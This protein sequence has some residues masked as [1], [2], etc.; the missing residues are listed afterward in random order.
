MTYPLTLTFMFLVFWRPQEWLVPAMYGWP[1]LDVIMFFAIVGL[2]MEA[3]QGQVRVPKTPAIWLCI[4]LWFATLASH[5]PSTYFKGIVDT[6]PDSFK[7]CFFVILLV[8]VVDRPSRAR[9]VILVL[10]AAAILMTVHALMQQRLGYGFAGQPPL[11]E[12]R[13][14]R[15]VWEVRSQFFGIFGD[16]NDLAQFLSCTIPLVFA[17]PRRMNAIIFCLCCGLAWYIFQGL[18]ACHSR[19]GMIALTTVG[20]CIVFLRLPIRWLPYAG[21]LALLGFLIL[22]LKA[23]LWLDQSARERIVFW[24]MA[25][26]VFKAH[27]LFGIGYGM[28]WQVIPQSR[29]C[30]NAF[31]SCY[32]E[33]GLFGYWFWFSLLQLG[34][35]GCWRTLMAM[36]QNPRQASHV[37]LKRLTGL[38]IAAMCGFTAGAYFLSRAFI[39]PYFFLFGLLCAIP[40]IAHQMLPDDHPPL[41]SYNRDVLGMGTF[42]TLFS[43]V[44]IYITILLLNKSYG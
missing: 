31:V 34:I 23:S 14:H 17:I 4:G 33:I 28:F 18:V 44:Y 36:K 26:R 42:S 24:G 30:H 41:V 13:P 43:I 25:N 6:A 39:F 9:G 21:A 37:Y 15:G 8:V 22:C 27:P 1:V 2:A 16:P 40:M 32:T 3:G 19:G 5:V 10:V 20:L 35:V 7:Y 11:L 12:Y 29:A 38:S